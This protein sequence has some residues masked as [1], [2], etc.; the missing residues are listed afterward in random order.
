LELTVEPPL[1]HPD[2]IRNRRLE[3][4]RLD[5][6]ALSQL[7]RENGERG[8]VVRATRPVTTVHVQVAGGDDRGAVFVGEV[9]D[10]PLESAACGRSCH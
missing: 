4:R 1:E 8:Q 2:T 5:L 10:R 3:L 6:G 7:L 9:A